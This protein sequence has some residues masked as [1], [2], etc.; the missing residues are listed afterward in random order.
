MGRYRDI[1]AEDEG[2]IIL[3]LQQRHRVRHIRL[4]M[5][6]S[7]LQKLVP[8]ID[9][10]FPMLDSLS[11][12]FSQEDPDKINLKLPKTLQAPQLRVLVL[13]NIDLSP[14]LQILTTSV[15]L[16]KLE[17]YEIYPAHFNP[18]ELFQRLSLLPQLKFL[19]I[20]FHDDASSTVINRQLLD[21]PVTTHHIP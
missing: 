21:S 20:D 10:E 2:G 3:A 6:G 8:A 16:V 13:T 17:L 14:V 5:P 15:S 18:N 4:L 1:T 11:L 9:G 19:T 12:A 7:N